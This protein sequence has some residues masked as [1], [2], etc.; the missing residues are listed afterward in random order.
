MKVI[1]T[2]M[3][4]KKN[5]EM[6]TKFN[7]LFLF[8][9][10]SKFVVLEGNIFASCFSN[11]IGRLRQEMQESVFGFAEGTILSNWRFYFQK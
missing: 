7:E 4:I 5:E 6:K 9:V 8:Y 3:R 10:C 2:L 1:L 11:W